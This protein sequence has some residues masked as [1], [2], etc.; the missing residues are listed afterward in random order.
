[1]AARPRRAAV[2]A[3][4]AGGRPEAG[5]GRPR[6]W[7]W[8]GRPAA[9]RARSSTRP[10]APASSAAAGRRPTRRPSTP[11]RRCRARPARCSTRSSACAGGSGWRRAGRP[12]SPS[13]PRWPTSREEA[14]ALADQYHEAHAA[15]AGL[16]AGLGPQPGRAAATCGWSSE[17]AHLFQRLA[18]HVI[19][20]GPDL[21]A[22]RPR[23]PPTVRARR[24]CGGTASPATGRSS[25]SAIARGGRAA[26]GPAAPR[27]ARV[28]GGCKGLEVDLVLLNEAA[29]ELPRGAPRAAPGLGPRRRH[30]RPGRQAGRRLRAQGGADGRRRTRRCSRR[31]PASSSLGDRGPLAGQLDR[32]ERTPALPAAPG[33]GATARRPGRHRP[34]NC[35]PDLLFANGLGGFTPGRPRVLHPRA[36]PRPPR[37]PAQRLIPATGRAPAAPAAR[38]LDQRRRQPRVRLPGLRG[39]VGLHLGRQ[40]P[41]EPP[42]A[43]EQRPGRRPARRGRLPARRGDRRGLDARRRC[44]SP[45]AAPTLV[46]HGQGYTVFE[47]EQPRPRPRADPVRPARRPG[48]GGPAEGRATRATGAG[49]SRRR[50]TPSGCWATTRDA[51]RHARRHR[52]RRRD[53]RPAGPERL[54]A[55]LRRAGG[56]RRRRPAAADVHGRPRRV[57]RPQRLGRRP[58]PPSG[59]SSCPAAS[60][61]ASTPAPPSRSKFDLEP[62]RGRGDRLPPRRGRRPRG[63]PRPACGATASRAGPPRRSTR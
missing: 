58:P 15:A 52:A 45:T 43:L 5:L 55:G 8:T 53:R 37:R 38:A 28:P 42:D 1:M 46:R 39:R 22:A 56:V 13:R 7:P 33:P 32:I 2:P 44:P 17:D 27:R 60:G 48:Q 41:D 25:W 26:A 16:R 18:A 9:S 14:L 10:T 54:P 11:A 31:P 4:A 12:A 24:A 63:G 20:A 49:G 51:R 6:R 30:G 36:M 62:G 35:P 21:R 57:P 23:S 47:Q 50:S 3:P 61:P 34:R 40:Q 19:F 59:G 29:D